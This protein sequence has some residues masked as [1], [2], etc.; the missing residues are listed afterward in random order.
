MKKLNEI[1]VQIEI[2]K[3]STSMLVP[4][5]HE[6]ATMLKGLKSSGKINMLDLRHEPL[7]L[8][9]IEILKDLLGQGE[10]NSNFN[11]L[12]ES[13]N[14]RETGVSGIWWITHYNQ[15]GNVKSE[16]IEITTCPEMLKTLPEELDTALLRLQEKISQYENSSTPEEIADRLNELGFPS[17]KFVANNHN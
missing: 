5:L 16:F 13:T 9:E 15:D 10:I 1:P 11:A 7:D 2:T 12:G 14:I 4:I 17:N 3:K 8:N 6:M